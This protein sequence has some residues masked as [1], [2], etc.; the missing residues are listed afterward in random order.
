MK[1]EVELIIEETDGVKSSDW[2]IRVGDRIAK[3]MTWDEMLGLF[4]QLTIQGMPAG[5]HLPCLQWLRTPEQWA[6]MERR[7]QEA[8]ARRAQREEPD[9]S[10][11]SIG[12]AIARGEELPT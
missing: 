12:E 3:F 7:H 9:S 8:I 10:E 5:N 4:V 6:E 2:Q 1:I 11:G